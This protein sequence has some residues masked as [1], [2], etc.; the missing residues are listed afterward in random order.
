M[1]TSE[2]PTV[3]EIIGTG[4][5]TI[6]DEASAEDAFWEGEAQRSRDLALEDD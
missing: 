5:V 4:Q 6:M 2:E 1:P 3:Y